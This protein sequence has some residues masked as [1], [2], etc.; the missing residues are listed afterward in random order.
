MA[1][2]YMAAGI[3]HFVHPEVY[4]K[5]MP[6]WLP[7][8]NTLVIMSGIAEI[9]LGLLLVP[10]YTRRLAAIGIIILLI[11]VFP[12]NVQMLLNYWREDHPRLWLAILRLPLQGLLIWWA[13]QYTKPL[14]KER[15]A[16]TK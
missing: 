15:E 8:H 13:Y 9:L 3:N 5:I 1:A 16:S 12:A 2:L 14:K 11:T 10:Y 4:Q 7:L 6:A